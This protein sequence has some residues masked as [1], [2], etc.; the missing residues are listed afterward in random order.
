MNQAKTF[1]VQWMVV[2]EQ[3]VGQEV[4][5]NEFPKQP[6]IITFYKCVSFQNVKELVAGVIIKSIHK[7]KSRDLN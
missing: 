4:K 5:V 6:D 3:A 7:C 2:V 1:V